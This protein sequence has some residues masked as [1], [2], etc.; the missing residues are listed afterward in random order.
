MMIAAR[1]GVI[2]VMTMAVLSRPIPAQ[3]G[4]LT[5]GRQVRVVSATDSSVHTGRL[6]FVVADTIVLERSGRQEWL[7]VDSR[8]RMDVLTHSHSFALVGALLGAGVGTALGSAQ[9]LHS[10]HWKPWLSDEQ[11]GLGQPLATIMFGLAGT[12]IG[13]LLG[14][15]LGTTLWEPV[16]PGQL[17][18]LRVGLAPQ[19]DGQLTLGVSLAF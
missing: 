3:Q 10:C 15:R 19:P 9:R 1:I 5:L 8:D 4:Q 17:G 18:E 11:C 7:R 12:G 14:S 2:T 13:A 6:V 16:Q